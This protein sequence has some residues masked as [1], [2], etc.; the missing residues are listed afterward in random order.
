[1]LATT[2]REAADAMVSRLKSRG[3]PAHISAGEY[4]GQELF[5]VRVGGYPDEAAAQQ[6]ARAIHEREGL[7][8]WVTR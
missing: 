3:F 8:T 5:R 7:Q 4:K 6:V 2:E 1:V